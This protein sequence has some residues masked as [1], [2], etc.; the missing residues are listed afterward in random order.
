M[1]SSAGWN[2]YP[3]H[4]GGLRRAETTL[5]KLLGSGNSQTTGLG[6]G[7]T[8]L[9]QAHRRGLPPVDPRAGSAKAEPQY[10]R[11]DAAQSFPPVW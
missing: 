2:R 7:T 5:A 6:A 9:E 10:S 3:A 4:L 8:Y 1:V 11:I